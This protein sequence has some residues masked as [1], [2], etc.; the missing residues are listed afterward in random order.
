MNVLTV[1]L[2]AIIICLALGY[3]RRGRSLRQ[4]ARQLELLRSSPGGRL[5]LS[6][7]DAALEPLLAQVNALLDGHEQE[8][9]TLRSREEDLRRQISNISH[10]LRTPLTSILGYL[11]LLEGEDLTPEERGEYLK[12]IDSRART[13]QTLITAFY[14]LSR[15]EGGEYSLER[16]AVD[17]HRLLGDLLAE[18]YG[19]FEQRGIAVE[20]ELEPGLPAVWADRRAAARV[21][22]NLL[23]NALKHG[24]GT[25][26]V[27][28]YREGEWVVTSFSNPAPALTREDMDHI[29]DRFYTADQMRTGRDTGL[30][31][32][33]VRALV[34]RMGHSV[35]AALE[36]GCFTAGVRWKI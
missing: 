13:L 29:F 5:R 32:A 20:A 35:W 9:R 11:Q 18:F 16:E 7:P 8:T 30:G 4:A 23:G 33:I 19:D 22:S 28:L 27:R 25:L 1:I 15:I 36:D 12:V 26:S 17:L 3:I 2:L 34:T 21:L 6:A 24:A 31:L 14:D 10:D